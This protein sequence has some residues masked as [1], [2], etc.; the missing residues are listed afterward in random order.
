MMVSSPFGGGRAPGG[1]PRLPTPPTGWPVR[2]DAAHGG[3]P[4]GRRLLL[5]GAARARP[6]RRP[7]PAALGRTGQGAAR[8]A[9]AQAAVCEP[10][11]NPTPTREKSRFD[12]RWAESLPIL[13]AGCDR[14]A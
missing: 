4:P 11:E 8:Q 10:L 5:G 13:L 12:E 7:V 2:A 14:P 6:L 3:A 1:L 9:G